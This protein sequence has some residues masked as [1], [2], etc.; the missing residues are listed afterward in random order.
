MNDAA[1]HIPLQ[2]GLRPAENQYG[3]RWQPPEQPKATTWATEPPSSVTLTDAERRVRDELEE[4]RLAG[5]ERVA[6]HGEAVRAA[7][8]A[9]DSE[10]A[11][12]F[13]LSPAQ[14]TEFEAAHADALRGPRTRVAEAQRTLDRAEEGQQRA[15]ALLREKAGALE[16]FK[17]LEEQAAADFAAAC[18]AALTS[19]EVPNPYRDWS[20]DDAAAQRRAEIE[21]RGA[22]QAVER[23]ASIVGK[24]RQQLEV[25]QHALRQAVD[26]ILAECHGRPLFERYRAILDEAERLRVELQGFRGVDMRGCLP[27]AGL[28]FSL[29]QRVEGA[30]VQ[31][32][33]DG[34]LY[35][36]RQRRDALIKAVPPAEPETAD[37]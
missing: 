3:E 5:R 30:S 37:A 32:S 33:V 15:A 9:R 8:R 23:F 10:I 20:A 12:N 25:A 7:Q 19:G 28:N 29:D 18:E 31:P 16:Q 17:H 35:S 24:S 1:Y 26:D 11:R 14:L 27:R 6:A 4:R 36:W 34:A 2:P 21:H 22:R 13:G